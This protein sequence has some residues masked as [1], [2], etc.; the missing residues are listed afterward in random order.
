MV[1]VA[2]ASLADG[3]LTP[4]LVLDTA[5]HGLAPGTRAFAIG[6]P[7]APPL[8]VWKDGALFLQPA[9]QPRDARIWELRPE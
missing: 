6:D 1:A 8:G 4:T 3:P 9:L 2:L 7:A 5:R